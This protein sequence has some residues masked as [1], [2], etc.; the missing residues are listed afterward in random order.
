MRVILTLTVVVILAI[1]TALATFK[2]YQ[3]PPL[4]INVPSVVLPVVDEK[5]KPYICSVNG[6]SAKRA[7]ATFLVSTESDYLESAIVLGRSILKHHHDDTTDMILM[8][9]DSSPLSCGAETGLK[10]AGWE[11]CRVPL[12]QPPN[13][14]P[15]FPRFRQQFTKLAL[16]T[17]TRYD[18]VVYMDADTMAVGPLDELFHAS[19]SDLPFAAS[20]D[21]ADGHFREGFNMGVFSMVPD[22]S[23]FDYLFEQMMTRTDYRLDMAEQG[24]MQKLYADQ[25]YYRLP[26][27][28]NANLAIFMQ[29]RRLWD[30][31]VPQMRVIHF[32]MV[33]PASL[34]PSDKKANW[35]PIKLWMETRDHPPTGTMKTP[36]DCA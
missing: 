19:Y 21:Y 12:I 5:Y 14:E 18:N 33:K 11:I 29:D 25:P 24:L 17:W 7:I 13:I 20:L 32:T 6:S 9:L 36:I 23:M 30:Q 15:I 35:A 26:L 22:L 28:L 34:H 4:P 10:R 3:V 2:P 8:L 31:N 16:F 1:L 27:T